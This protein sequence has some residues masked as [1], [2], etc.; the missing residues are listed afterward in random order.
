MFVDAVSCVKRHA[1]D[2]L[3]TAWYNKKSD[4][5]FSDIIA[6]VRRSIWVKNHFNDSMFDGDHVKIKRKQYAKL[7]RLVF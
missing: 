4:A 2:V 7:F 6:Y 1:V 5:T 3:S